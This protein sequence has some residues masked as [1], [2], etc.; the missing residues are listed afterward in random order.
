MTG[1]AVRSTANLMRRIGSVP[2]RILV[3]AAMLVLSCP[4]LFPQLAVNIIGTIRDTAGDVINANVSVQ[5]ETLEGNFV[6]RSPVNQNGRFS[7]P[8]MNKIDYILVVTAKGYEPYQAKLNS[9]YTFGDYV[10]DVTLTPAYTIKQKPEA[11]PSLTDMR[12]PKQAQKEYQKGAKALAGKNLKSAQAHFESALDVFPCYARAQTG[13]ATVLMV[14]H[15]GAHAEKALRK[16]IKCDP[17]FL[18]AYIELGELLNGQ[19]KFSDSVSVL[20]EGVRR[21]PASWQFYFQLGV[22][23]TGLK[24]YPA[25]EASFKRVLSFN[26]HPPSQYYVKLADLYVKEKAFDKAYEQMQHYLKINPR[27]RFAPRIKQIMQQMRAAGVL[28][29]ADSGAD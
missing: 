24:Q 20:Q 6:A 22:A 7:F 8:G 10:H 11:L 3:L 25:A 29:S 21:S 15:E 14:K 28:H 27:G 4:Y 19:N 9:R 17:G 13:L 1:A 12:A 18:D 5:L 16:S 26:P 2:R 23:Q